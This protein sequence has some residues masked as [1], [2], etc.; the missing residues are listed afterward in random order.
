MPT[1]TPAGIFLNTRRI[2]W[3]TEKMHSRG[4]TI[5]ALHGDMDQKERDVIMRELAWLKQSTHRYGLTGSELMC[6]RFL[7][8]LPTKRENNIE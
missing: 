1:V 7:G 8:H 6:S 4:F 3:L 2:C 5:S